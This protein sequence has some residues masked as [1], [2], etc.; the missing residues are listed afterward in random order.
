L[1]KKKKT[2]NPKTTTTKKLLY[3]AYALRYW[4]LSKNYCLICILLFYC[5]IFLFIY[6]S[7]ILI[8]TPIPFHL[9]QSL[10]TDSL[11]SPQGGWEP[12]PTM[13][14][15]DSAELGMSFPTE[16]RQ[17]IPV[18]EAVCT[19]RNS[20]RDMSRSGCWGPHE[21][22]AAY[23]LHICCGPP[24]CHAHSGEVCLAGQEAWKHSR[25]KEYHGSSPPGV[26]AFSLT[27]I[28][29][30]YSRVSLVYGYTCSLLVLS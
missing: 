1:A 13:A 24:S 20:L 4:V 7:Y 5:S 25:G 19:D 3:L 17:C 12:P 30:P 23:P 15:Q 10:I 18:R 8:G 2:K 6:S 28:L 11:L 14:C 26:L 21:G 16:V 22:W 27:H 29:I 9:P